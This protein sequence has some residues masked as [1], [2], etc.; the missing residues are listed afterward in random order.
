MAYNTS[1]P[2]DL[3]L[4]Q[5][6]ET[7]DPV[8]SAELARIYNAIRQLA[9]W[10]SNET[11]AIPRDTLDWAELRPTD[12]IKNQN[13]NR[14]YVRAAET[15]NFGDI[16][17]YTET[18]GVLEARKANANSAGIRPAHGFCSQVGG[19][20]VGTYGETVA[21]V[22]LCIGIGGMIPGN[23][24][25]LSTTAGLI[26][27]AKPAGPHLGQPIGFALNSQSLFFIAAQI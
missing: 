14:C 19:I 3:R 17:N 10:A 13:A 8:L 21:G 24:Y 12:T 16:V 22:G 11:G 5:N 1:F 25:Y 2:V 9:I 18:G 27:N 4:P 6:P 20:P 26:I 7:N 15:L 23:T